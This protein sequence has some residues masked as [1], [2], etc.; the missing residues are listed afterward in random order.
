MEFPRSNAGFFRGLCARVKRNP[1][2]NSHGRAFL[3]RGDRSP[4][5]ARVFRFHSLCETPVQREITGVSHIGAKLN[6]RSW[7]VGQLPLPSLE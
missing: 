5:L 2:H 6:V 4:C 7:N 3:A 1:Q